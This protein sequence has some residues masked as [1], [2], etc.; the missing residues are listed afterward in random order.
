MQ[1]TAALSAPA[2]GS[3]VTGPLTVTGTAADPNLLDYRLAVWAGPRGAGQ[4]YRLCG[5]HRGG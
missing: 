5:F 4:V 1:L 2:E 3:Y